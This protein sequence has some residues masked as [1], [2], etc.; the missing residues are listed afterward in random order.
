M[1]RDCVASLRGHSVRPRYALL[2]FNSTSGTKLRR[3]NYRDTRVSCRMPNGSA[4]GGVS[5]QSEDGRALPER[6]RRL[7]VA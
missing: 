3:V 6:A 7:A 5:W 1:R 2:Q 4:L